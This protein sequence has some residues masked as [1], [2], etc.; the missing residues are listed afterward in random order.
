MRLV[1]GGPD[2]SILHINNEINN[3]LELININSASMDTG[4]Y[5]ASVLWSYGKKIH[6]ISPFLIKNIKEKCQLILQPSSNQF[7]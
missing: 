2:R 6:S 4:L 5:S 1:L 3:D 7:F